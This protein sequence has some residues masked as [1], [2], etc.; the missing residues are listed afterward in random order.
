MSTSLTRNGSILIG[1]LRER[2]RGEVIGPNDLGYDDARRTFA[3]NFDKRP[4]VIVRPV[5]D[6]KSRPSCASPPTRVWSSR[7]EAAGTV[8]RATQCR[9]VASSSTS[10]HGSA[11]TWTSTDGRP[12]QRQA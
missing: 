10:R 12:G 8:E 2:L 6:G 9:R 5:D 11:S 3:G 7:S 4:A 1:G